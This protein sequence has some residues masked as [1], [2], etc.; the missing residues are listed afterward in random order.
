MTARELTNLLDEIRAN[1]D[2]LIREAE[3]SDAPSDALE[4]LDDINTRLQGI[5]FRHQRSY[6][7]APE[8]SIDE[9]I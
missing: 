7:D 2:A 8:P 1:V 9:M 5:S 4:A 6:D 3:E